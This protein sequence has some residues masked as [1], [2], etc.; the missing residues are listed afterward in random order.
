MGCAVLAAL[1]LTAA[2]AHAASRRTPTLA[3]TDTVID[4]PDPGIDSL[5]GMAI[6]RDGNGGLV[7]T[8]DVAGVTHVFV[9]RLLAGTWMPPVQVDAGLVPPSS[10]PVIAAT[11][12]GLLIV[13][14][15]NGGNLYV[16]QAGSTSVPFSTP[17]ALYPGASNPAISLSTF[18]K[19]YVAFTATGGDGTDVKAAYYW[20]GVWTVD[21]GVLDDSPGDNA[22]SGTGRPAVATSGDGIAIVAWGE[23]GHVFTRRV[24][25][26]AL[27]VVDER[28]DAPS[29]S[30]FNE[31]SSG[32]PS[33][34]TGG[35]SS[36][37]TVAFRE[38]LSNGT[39]TQ[40]RVFV[41]RL[42]GSQYDDFDPNADGAVAG[43]PEGADSP[44]AQ[45]SEYGAGWVTSEDDQ[46]HQLY[47]TLINQTEA[48]S[49]AE[50]V[51]SQFNLNN[52]DA[53]PAAAG[54]YSTLIAWQQTP[55]VSGPAEIRLRY[56]PDGSDL[57]PEQIASSPAF[58]ATNAD[59]GLAAAGD[60]AGDAAVAWV[61]GS[62]ASTRIV[63]AQLYQ[64]P[65]SFG[66]TKSFRYA[67][68]GQPILAWSQSSESWGPITYEVTF[69]GTPIILTRSLSARTPGVVGN[70]RH[71]WVATAINAA[72]QRVTAKA[73]TVFVDTVKPRASF[74]LSGPGV[75]KDTE[76]VRVTDSDH[77]PLGLP[78]SD[79]SG[80]ASVQV[81]WGDG[82][83]SKLSGHTKTHVY[84]RRR[85]YRVTLIVKD[86]AGNKTTITHKLKIRGKAG[87]KR[88]RKSHKG[89]RR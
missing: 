81:R 2:S 42:H 50:R 78:K 86:R 80:V 65:G 64:S 20:Q 24:D 56:A 87:H 17:Q 49:T 5:T 76:R 29:V 88:S 47:A 83:T 9:S 15:I 51:D 77:P 43:G 30:G 46:S 48:P 62:G 33:V 84:K 67:T 52:P 16:T 57:G 14:F 72:G 19:A 55:G 23:G 18:G 66:P 59:D 82:T 4:G 12:G 54:L 70:G 39:T 7:Y 3:P 32:D 22:G 10:Q 45:V 6:A 61:Q 11:N 60:N 8:K 35:D 13:A 41:S 40:S 69:D 58:G 85:T 79:A 1:V 89:V 38:T 63:T 73:A 27:S 25:H 37:A 68:S 44:R 28:A 75:A 21:A 34:S 31:V 36:Y 26:T 53:V 74:K 71:T